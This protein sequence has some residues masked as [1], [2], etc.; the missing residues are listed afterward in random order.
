MITPA[1]VYS[2]E[3]TND[4]VSQLTT[5]LGKVGAKTNL[6]SDKN[7]NAVIGNII[8]IVL[9]FLG[10]LAVIYIIYAGYRWITAA[11]NEQ[12]VTEA[13]VTIRNAVYG[14]MVVLLSWAIIS[15]VIDNIADSSKD[16]GS[17]S[18]S[19]PSSCF[20]EVSES[21]CATLCLDRPTGAKCPATQGY[22]ACSGATAQL[23]GQY[24]GTCTETCATCPTP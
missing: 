17:G 11:G 8:N 7:I 4:G 18:I 2:A 22:A 24:S 12:T 23:A 3:D 1:L 14:I 21:V 9:G 16:G 5:N 15:F 13:K 19:G 20:Y 10:I 6:S